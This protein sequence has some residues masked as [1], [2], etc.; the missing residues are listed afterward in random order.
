VNRLKGIDID[1]IE[2][3]QI[4]EHWGEADTVGMLIQMGVDP[5]V[6]RAAS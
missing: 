1:R 4:V 5:F 3:G 6:G 2:N